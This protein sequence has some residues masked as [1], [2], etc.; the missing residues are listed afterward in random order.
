M[1]H[2]TDMLTCQSTNFN[3]GGR[4]D[5]TGRYGAVEQVQDEN[6]EGRNQRDHDYR[7]M[8]YRSYLRD[9]NSQEP[10]ND[11]DDSSEEH[12]VE[13]SYEASSGSETQHR[14]RD[15]PNEHLGF[16]GDGDYRDQDYRTEQEEEEQKAS[17]I[18]MLRMLPQS[19]TESD[20]RAQLQAHGFQPR[21]VRLMRNKASG[22]S[23][24]FAFVE[25]NHL[26]DATRWMEANQVALL[27]LK[28]TSTATVND[29]SQHLVHVTN[30][31]CLPP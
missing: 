19:A 23:R 6:S 27:H 1:K 30:P 14:K 21:E 12:S 17:S 28:P 8:D 10:A 24:G 16:P 29:Q 9:F 18:I 5:R 11:Y 15:S 26:Q 31:R 25:F 2:I 20:I 22:Q 4:G 3:R 7:D 13:D